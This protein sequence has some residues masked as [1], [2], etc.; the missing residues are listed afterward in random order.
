MLERL[1]RSLFSFSSSL[2]SFSSSVFCSLLFSSVFSRLLSARA[3]ARSRSPAAVL[4]RLGCC[5]QRCGRV[6]ARGR[7]LGAPKY[8]RRLTRGALLAGRYDMLHLAGCSWCALLG[9]RASLLYVAV[10]IAARCCCARFVAARCCTRFFT[11]LHLAVR[12]GSNCCTLLYAGGRSA[13]RSGSRA[14]NTPFFLF[15]R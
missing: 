3:G 9:T 6:V 4:Q 8:G 14:I 13:A 2:F 15:Y 10:H 11:L 7:P 1:K 5:P 12:R